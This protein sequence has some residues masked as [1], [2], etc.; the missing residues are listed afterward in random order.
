MSKQLDLQQLS[1]LDDSLQGHVSER[2]GTYLLQIKAC[3]S[4]DYKTM[5]AARVKR[6]GYLIISVY[7]FCFD[8]YTTVG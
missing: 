8:Q 7:T 6:V 3:D 4:G 2:N 1:S 5:N